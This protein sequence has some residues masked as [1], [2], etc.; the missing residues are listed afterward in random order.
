M[1]TVVA[2]TG[3]VL[4][5]RQNERLSDGGGVRTAGTIR[6][7][8]PTA[9][10]EINSSTAAPEQPA[11]LNSDVQGVLHLLHYKRPSFNAVNPFQTTTI[12][13]SPRSRII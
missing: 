12:S 9:L 10:C 3:D 1:L 8:S 2:H 13:E 11:S 7:P 6:R 5:A 4:S